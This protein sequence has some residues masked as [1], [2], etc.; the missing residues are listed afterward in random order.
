MPRDRRATVDS[1]AMS[2]MHSALLTRIYERAWR[3]AVVRAL[4]TLTYAAE[5]AI[6]D[7]H[8]E[9]RSHLRLLD[10]CCGTA[11]TSRHWI[12][13]HAD[14]LGIDLSLAMLREARRRTPSERLVLVQADAGSPIAQAGTFDAAFCFAALHLLER[15]ENVLSAAAEALRPHGLFFAWVATSSGRMRAGPVQ[16]LTRALGLLLWEPKQLMVRLVAHG[17][18]IREI[19]SFGAIEFAVAQLLQ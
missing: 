5:D 3:P 7:R 19:Q 9:R 10:L 15:P 12:P 13:R 17:F 1:W 11:R 16:R 18:E 8:L 2:L 14:V 6:V 4:S